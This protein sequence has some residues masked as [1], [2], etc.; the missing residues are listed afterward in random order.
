MAQRFDLAGHPVWDRHPPRSIAR[1]PGIEKVRQWIR[2]WRILCA[3]CYTN[4]CTVQVEV[5]P[6][7]QGALCQGRG[8]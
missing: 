6:A 3:L 8:T 2:Q 4:S 5:S 1:Q 7:C